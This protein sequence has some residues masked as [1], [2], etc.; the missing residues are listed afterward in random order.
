M[1]SLDSR[2]KILASFVIF[3]DKLTNRWDT[4]SLANFDLL[5]AVAPPVYSTN[6]AI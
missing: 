2:S 3:F 6:T 4:T 1:G 5:Q